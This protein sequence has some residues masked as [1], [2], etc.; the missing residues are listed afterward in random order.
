MELGD[1]IGNRGRMAEDL[2]A[3]LQAAGRGRVV[4]SHALGAA[5]DGRAALLK[6]ILFG[7]AVETYALPA[8]LAYGLIDRIGQAVEA[9][10]IRD[11]RADAL[12][13]SPEAQQIALYAAIR[14]VIDD[15]DWEGGARMFVSQL[16]AHAFGNALGLRIVAQ[17]S[18]FLLVLPDQVAILLHES[19]ILVAS[20]LADRT[21]PPA[22]R[23]EH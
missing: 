15:A 12:P 14:P 18:E 9:G 17:G 7:G 13:G 22:S 5:D 2:Q 19:L 23:S 20:Y 11:R 21:H 8:A 1:W 6:V 16:D 3:R 10:A 4:V